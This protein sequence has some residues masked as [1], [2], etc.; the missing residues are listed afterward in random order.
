MEDT[1]RLAQNCFSY[2]IALDSRLGYVSGVI[3]SIGAE[4]TEFKK[5]DEVYS[6]PNITRNG[7]YAE[8]VAIK[9]SEVAYKPRSIDHVTAAAVPLAGLTAWQALFDH[10]KL[11]HGQ[12]VL[13]IG[14]SGGVGSF[15]VQ[16]A[17][18][19][20]ANVIGVCSSKNVNFLKSLGTDQVIDYK[21]VNFQDV[22]KNADLVFDAAG[23]DSKAQAWKVLKSGGKFVS[24]TGKP[25][26]E[27]PADKDKEG[28]GFTVQPSKDQLTQIAKLIDKGIVQ[29][30]V[31]IVLPL[32]DAREAQN[33]LQQGQNARGKIVLR[34]L[35]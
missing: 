31:S 23:S 11:E 6:R 14:A 33:M 5:G 32:S 22:V 4:V 8:F 24:I 21:T 20:K 15:A 26:S 29:P 28:I 27:D 1:R 17:K 9:S 2:H 16:F 7:T 19:K 35:E 25:V 18:W 10:G 30:I 34:V 12:K 3:E 13:I